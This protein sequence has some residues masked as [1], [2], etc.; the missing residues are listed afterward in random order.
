[1]ARLRCYGLPQAASGASVRAVAAL[2]LAAGAL[3]APAPLIDQLTLGVDYYPEACV[4]RVC[5]PRGA[6]CAT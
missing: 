4:W 2:A 5:P 6:R 3:A 1:M